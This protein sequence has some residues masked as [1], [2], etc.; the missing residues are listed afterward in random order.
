M[1]T[2]DEG[3]RRSE[4]SERGAVEG[5]TASIKNGSAH[6]IT[7]GDLKRIDEA[8][9]SFQEKA[10]SAHCILIAGP[11]GMATDPKLL[12]ENAVAAYCQERFRYP[13]AAPSETVDII[14]DSTG[15][16]LDSAYKIVLYLSRFASKIRVF[17]PRQAK[18]ASTLIALGAHELRMSPFGELGP[19]DAQIRDPRNPEDRMSALDCYQSVDYVRKF[20]LDTLREA[21]WQLAGYTRGRMTLPDLLKIASEF[22]LGG[23]SPVLSQVN[24]LDFGSWG[25]SLT[26]GEKYAEV[27]LRKAAADGPTSERIADRLVYGYTHH[28]F[29][30]DYEEAADIGLSPEVMSEAEYQSSMAAVEACHDGSYV[31]FIGPAPT[32]APAEKAPAESRRGDQEK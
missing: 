30:I 14:L 6:K 12:T 5:I 18:S 10:E 22:A 24:A 4:A 9:R 29:P 1:P 19:L 21:L 25:R 28:F 32:P 2:P 15:G 31:G 16:S 27:I 13:D 8:G 11:L 26:I 3:Q 20:G 23:I 17:V 7:V